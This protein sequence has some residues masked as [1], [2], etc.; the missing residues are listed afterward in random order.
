MLL[1]DHSPTSTWSFSLLLV[2]LQPALLVLA[3]PAAA[4]MCDLDEN[5]A[6]TLLLPYFEVNRANPEAGNTIFTINNAL[7]EPALA[8]VTFW[9]DWSH[10][11]INFDLFLTGYDVVSV[12]L[13]DVFVRGDV[14]ITADQQTDPLDDISPHGGFRPDGGLVGEPHPEWDTSFTTCFDFFPFYVNPVI[15]GDN[16][17]RLVD[18]HTGQPLDE[19]GGACLGADFGDDVARGYVTIDNAS[20]CS[21]QFPSDAGYFDPDSGIAVNVNQLWGDWIY[22]DREHGFAHGDSLVHIEALDGFDARGDGT[23]DSLVSDPATGTTFYGRYT[24]QGEDNREPL[25]VAWGVRYINNALFAPGGTELTV[26]RDPTVDR[27]SDGFGYAC[28]GP[29][30]SGTGPV[31]HPLDETL[32]LAFDDFENV[33]DLCSPTGCPVCSSPFVINPKCF[34]LS[35]QRTDSDDL[36]LAGAPWGAGWMYLDLRLAE[37]QPGTLGELSQSFVSATHSAQGLLSIG[38][39]AIELSS[40]CSAFNE[41]QTPE[42]SATWPF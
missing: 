1:S 7:P 18:G 32:V 2:L 13:A 17:N 10:P 16:F 11:T 15:F 40:A 35:T 21:T 37:D 33:V 6:A 30:A 23:A 22:F 9:T 12:N 39:P 38:L 14:P 19:L 20:R 3:A 5:P 8:H 27:S 4:G 28:G 41:S 42:H 31:W 34:P 29:G 24:A 25:G 36:A 26:W